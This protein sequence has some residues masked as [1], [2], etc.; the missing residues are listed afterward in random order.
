MVTK[1]LIP[2]TN[3]AANLTVMHLDK[4]LA[5]AEADSVSTLGNPHTPYKFSSSTIATSTGSNN[6]SVSPSMSGQSI[7]SID[8]RVSNIENKINSLEVTLTQ[9]IKNSMEQVMRNFQPA[10]D[11]SSGS[12]L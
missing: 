8:S 1:P 9:T 12:E 11:S 4:V 6:S 5:G 3:T 10:G 2:G 7:A